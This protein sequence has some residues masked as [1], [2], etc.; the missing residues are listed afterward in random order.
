MCS[1]DCGRVVEQLTSLSDCWS[2]FGSPNPKPG[3]C[4]KQFISKSM[5]VQDFHPEEI[6][7][8]SG[9]EQQSDNGSPS[10][11]SSALARSA[12]MSSG[13]EGPAGA[14]ALAPAK[15]PE[16]GDVVVLGKGVPSEFI[17]RPGVVMAVADAHCTVAVLDETGCFGIGECWPNFHD[18]KI[19]SQQWRLGARVV[20]AGLKSNRTKHLNGRSG[21]IITHPRSGHPT[22]ICK[23][24]APDQPILT[25]CIA[26]DDQADT[27]NK[28]VL[29]DA[30]YLQPYDVSIEQALV[31]LHDVLPASAPAK[32]ARTAA[33]WLH[34]PGPL[35][36]SD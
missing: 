20:L 19:Q 26:F 6:L 31:S 11:C 36:P 4:D 1:K 8:H 15:R 12:R 17:G 14:C 5:S 33:E 28:P 2:W 7:F 24:K 32:P 9:L 3:R 30:K 23:D 18:F 13:G 22:L 27:S 35:D 16:S 10:S 29:L 25:M 21:R 34:T